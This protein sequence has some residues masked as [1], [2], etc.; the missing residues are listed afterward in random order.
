VLGEILIYV[1]KQVLKSTATH[2]DRQTS[3]KQT[4]NK[5]TKQNSGKILWQQHK[6]EI[7]YCKIWGVDDNSI[8]CGVIPCWL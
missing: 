7:S 3:K 8:L 6:R 2:T 4:Q 1:S 5:H